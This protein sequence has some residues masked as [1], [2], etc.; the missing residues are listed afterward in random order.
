MAFGNWEMQAGDPSNFA[1]SIAFMR[2]PHGDEDRATPEERESWGAFSVWV[3]GENICAHI[4]QGEILDSAHWYMLPFIEWIIENWDCLLH[5]E[6]LPLL[7][8]G[9]S[10]AEALNI[11]RI[12]Q[13]SLKEVDE[14]AWMDSW[15]T[16][17]QRHNVRSGREGGLFPDLY[18]RRYRDNLELSTGAEPL[19][20]IPD[21]YVF[22]SPNRRYQA[23][24]AGVVEALYA[25]V[26]SAAHELRRRLPDS[27]RIEKL[28][29]NI[30]DLSSPDRGPIRMAWLA[31]LGDQMERYLE[32]AA[33]VDAAL[34]PVNPAIREQI[35]GARRST[36]LFVDGSAYARLLYGAISPTTTLADIAMLTELV[37][38]NYVADATPWL[39]RFEIPLDVAEVSQLPPWEQGSRLGEQ[40]CE[41]LVAGSETWIDV[42]AVL[43]ALDVNSASIEL[44]DEAIRA[45]SVFGP[46]QPP[47]IYRNSRTR[48]GPSP[49]VERFTLAHEL[50]HLLLDREYGDE[51]AIA[52][53]PWAPVAI[54]QRAN[55]FAAAF[56]MP[57]WLLRDTLN[58]VGGH[59]DNPE[60]IR[61]VSATLRVSRS[62]LVDRLFNLG[63]LTFDDRIRL[64]S[65]WP[66]GK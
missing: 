41:L 63:E 62:S 35:T 64:R 18:V 32:I 53:G 7:N 51:L 21:D 16:W 58:Q 47:H 46:T 43:Q 37:V 11:S 4:E 27:L 8:A 3:H 34:E 25:V 59:V 30:A 57:T 38:R 12:P 17:W 23:D 45:V 56:L 2:N 14:F 52:T 66:P 65:V 22:L 55:A 26:S 49:E 39:S 61:A 48:W 29:A 50:C 36:P 42:S 31:G 5:E 33:Q 60:T 6:R 15:S 40:A 19:P 44:S 28:E 10:A 54:E 20:G 1:L 9:L 24:L 13:L